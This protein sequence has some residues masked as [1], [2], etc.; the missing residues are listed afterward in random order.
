[1]SQESAKLIPVAERC[2]VCKGEGTVAYIQ[3]A[4]G[5][6][7]PADCYKCN[8]TGRALSS[9]HHQDAAK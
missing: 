7:E 5:F 6:S 1:M 3:S 2:D 8:G 4:G 9:T